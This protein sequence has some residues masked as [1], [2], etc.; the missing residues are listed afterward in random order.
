MANVELDVAKLKALE[1]ST[2]H[3][4]LA[5]LLEKHRLPQIVKI[6]E[7]FYGEGND[8]TLCSGAI[9]CLQSVK[10]I[11]KVH[12]RLNWG[13]GKEISIPLDCRCKVEVRSSNLKDVYESIEEL[14]SVFPKY[15]RVVQ[16]CHIESSSEALL[17]VGDKLHLK[18]N[19]NKKMTEMIVCINQ[20]DEEIQLPK[21]CV[22]CFQPLVDGKEYYL[23]DALKKFK[24]PLNVQFVEFDSIGEDGRSDNRPPFQPFRTIC[25]DR[26]SK[27][28]VI[29]G[30]TILAD[31][32]K[33][34]M[35]VSPDVD[36]EL[37]VCE[38][39]FQNSADYAKVLQILSEGATSKDSN[40]QPHK[41]GNV[42]EIQKSTQA[43]LTQPAALKPCAKEPK[44]VVLPK[45]KT[46]TSNLSHA[47][48]D[49]IYEEIRLNEGEHSECQL[50]IKDSTCTA[51][52]PTDISNHQYEK[53]TEN[54][55]SQSSEKHLNKPRDS[56]PIRL[57]ATFKVGDCKHPI[58]NNRS[59][60]TNTKPDRAAKLV[61]SWSTSSDTHP[62][63]P[64]TIPDCPTKTPD[65]HPTSEYMKE[66]IYQAIA[67]YPS[68]LSS[69]NVGAV[70]RLLNYLGM[71]KHVEL[72]ADELIDGSM[73]ASMD[74]KSLQSL[75]VD[76]FH[77]TKLLKFI[78]G[79]RPKV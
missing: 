1:W 46:R 39:S 71:E 50:V 70:G 62:Q 49:P 24:M 2:V 67:T 21:D 60:D 29:E 74:R 53:P 57:P 30:T 35:Q 25:L 44:P 31:G 56:L 11:Q 43:K 4:S 41:S 64:Y 28:K 23:S 18:A 51:L 78:D 27:E 59:E 65:V 37:V 63:N 45:P 14:C 36:I 77:V 13:R 3:L 40:T 75:N 79:W 38:D 76:S 32:Q 16:G 17:N 22:A 55:L 9:I 15:V 26:I 73:L 33:L 54:L 58:T 47:E 19:K 68:D 20:Y 6:I 7:G 48:Q 5:Q 69:L 72:F 66:E 8:S 52:D 61:E 34:S 42:D 10:A 12:G